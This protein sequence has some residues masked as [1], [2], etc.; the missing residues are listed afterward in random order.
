MRNPISIILPTLC[1][2]LSVDNVEGQ[3][4]LFTSPFGIQTYTFRRSIN[5]DPAKTLDTIQSLGFTEIE[6]SS[7]AV[8]PAEFRK[9]C[10]A[11][12]L[13]IASTGAGFDELSEKPDSV[14]LRAKALG[15]RFVMCAWIPHKSGEFNLQDAQKAV[16]VFN[17]AG[18]LLSEQGITLCYHAHGYEFQLHETG[19]LLDYLISQTDPRWVSFEMDIYWIHFGGGD[20]VSLLNKYGSR[21]KLMHVKDMR[22]GIAKD[23]TGLTSPENDV[24]LGTGQLDLPAILRAAKKAGIRHYF[25]ED[26]SSRIL[27]QLPRSM[28]Y[29]RGLKE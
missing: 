24:A 3:R 6:G 9:L 27:E 11:R 18:R 13:K 26:E 28:A 4:S 2:L 7:S 15:A 25:F 1:L 20:P 21:W 12:K 8:S 29:L 23:L 5:L 10:E 14:I 16:K 17:E 22:K 19:T